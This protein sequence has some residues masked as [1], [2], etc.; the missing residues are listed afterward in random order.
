MFN[1]LQIQRLNDDDTV[2]KIINVPLAY[3]PR[4]GFLVKLREDIKRADGPNIAITL[5]RMSFEMTG[6]SYD[7]DRQ[8]NP[9]GK[10][11][12]A[13]TTDSD[14]MKT[15]FAPVPFAVQ[16]DLSIYSQNID[17]SLQIVEQILPYF[18]PSVNITLNEIAELGM[19][20][21]IEVTMDAPNLSIDDEGIIG[22]GRTT[23]WSLPFT[24]NG[25]IW[26]PITDSG[27][28]KT[29]IANLYNDTATPPN[30]DAIITLYVDPLTA[31]ITDDWV[32]TEVIVE[33]S[34]ASSI[35]SPDFAPAFD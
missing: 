27:V 35:F 4:R 3:G 33:S 6:L 16:F 9:L 24:C 34:D 17:D 13:H 28:I 12:K 30:L 32:A 29:V 5:P 31:K 23:I 18:A 21:D 14:L 8:T 19:K 20:K 22:D 25:Y 15:Q 7:S 10:H 1:E 11:A 26:P 2:N